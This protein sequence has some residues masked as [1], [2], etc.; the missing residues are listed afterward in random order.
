M[1]ERRIILDA[2][3]PSRRL[4]P[5]RRVRRFR[6]AILLACGIALLSAGYGVYRW[7]VSPERVLAQ[8][9]AAL[10]HRDG[11][12]I[13][14]TVDAEELRHLHLESS[15]IVP[16][17]D[18]ATGQVGGLFVADLRH[19]QLNEE[20]SRYNRSVSVGL[21]DRAGRPI[22]G[23]GGKPARAWAYAYRTPRGWK[24]GLTNFI[25][26][27]TYERRRAGDRV[28]YAEL[29]DRF[30]MPPETFLPQEGAWRPIRRRDR[31]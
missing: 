19:E 11:R 15:E 20:Q 14:A 24:V 26:S 10:R 22:R 4:A 3:Q 21:C 31:H 16:L 29:C 1:G 25:Y 6:R 17:L 7:W 13:V 18:A 9:V 5:R 30:G 27:V 12:A 8:F 28:R 23:F 2:P